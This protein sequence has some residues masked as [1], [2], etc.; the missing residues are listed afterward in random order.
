MQVV[1]CSACS[2][3]G[4]KFATV[5][6]QALAELAVGGSTQHDIGFLR[7]HA[8]RPGHVALLERFNLGTA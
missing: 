8:D 4:Y 6:G 3:H 2:G 7:I 5:C 1:V